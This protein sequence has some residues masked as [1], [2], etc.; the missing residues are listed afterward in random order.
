MNYNVIKTTRALYLIVK[1]IRL[2]LKNYESSGGSRPSV[3]ERG[4]GG[5]EGVGG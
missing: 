4:G 5:G 3:K 1:Y 2:H